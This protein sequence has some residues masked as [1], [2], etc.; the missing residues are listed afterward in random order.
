MEYT[1][2]IVIMF[3]CAL[4]ASN[5]MNNLEKMIKYQQYTID[6]LS[7]QLGVP[8]HPINDVVRKKLKEDKYVEAIK[9]IRE[10]LNMS[11]PE[12]KKYVDAIKD[13]M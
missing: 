12:A 9:E 4:A 8:E 3:I 6:K 13:D 10:V 7:K 5:K 11:L 1:F 2:L